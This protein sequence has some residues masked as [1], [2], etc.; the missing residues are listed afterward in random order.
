[1][2]NI[3]AVYDVLLRDSMR[4]IEGWKDIAT[5]AI[6]DRDEAKAKLAEMQATQPVQ[7]RS[8]DAVLLEEVEHL[9]AENELLNKKL[10]VHEHTK[11][12]LNEAWE[13]KRKL[14]DENNILQDE[15][16]EQKRYINSLLLKG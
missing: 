4:L 6:S 12:L 3:D 13:E 1:M 9:R 11:F 2:S 16:K 14:Q 15:V 5:K 10:V 8:M 7:V